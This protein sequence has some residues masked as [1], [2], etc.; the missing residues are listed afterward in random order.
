VIGERMGVGPII[1]HMLP[2]GLA[3]M[4]FNFFRTAVGNRSFSSPS[5]PQT[6]QRQIRLRSDL[7]GSQ[8]PREHRDVYYR[9][10]SFPMTPLTI[11]K[12]RVMKLRSMAVLENRKP[13][14]RNKASITIAAK[15]G[16]SKGG[17]PLY[18]LLPK[19]DDLV[20]KFGQLI[21]MVKR[22]RDQ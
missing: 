16:R 18:G 14:S 19:K 7:S 9:T 12:I 10:D 15:R 4:L 3:C 17:Q 22:S 6:R 8:L 21:Y 2:R 20:G 11:A 13:S 1:L 5:L